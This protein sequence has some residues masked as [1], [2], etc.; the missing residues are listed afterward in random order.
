[1]PR[2]LTRLLMAAVAAAV[3]WRAAQ[4]VSPAHRRAAPRPE[5][6]RAPRPAAPT[7]DRPFPDEAA[8]EPALEPTAAA[9][10]PGDGEPR[11][12]F[13][14]VLVLGGFLLL[15]MVVVDVGWRGLHRLPQPAVWGLVDTDPERGRQAI[16]RHGCG[17]CHVIPGIST[18]V[19]RV[20]PQ[21]VDFGNQT[22]VAGV[23]ANVPEN[24]VRWLM[25]PQE[26][27]PLTAMPDLG[28]TEQEARDI[29][30]YL[31]ANP[32]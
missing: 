5:P 12:G 24:L 23:L 19:G 29:A 21:L 8:L 16:L 10:A 17:S 7:L 22:F 2:D 31:Y 14:S 13:L 18:A 6:V 32:R 1:M 9:P 20:G 25:H 28:V 11:V 4:A 15:G 26:I 27:N 30:A 3:A